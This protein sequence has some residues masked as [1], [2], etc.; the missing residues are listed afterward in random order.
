MKRTAQDILAERRSVIQE[1]RKERD[2]MARAILQY[3]INQLDAELG[4]IDA[5]R[6]A[7]GWRP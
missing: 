5:Q 4:A 7:P 3:Q 6:Y 1:Q 2:Q